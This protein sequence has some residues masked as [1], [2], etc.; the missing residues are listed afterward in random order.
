MYNNNN[1]SK[2]EQILKHMKNNIIILLATIFIL[3]CQQE[4]ELDTNDISII[5]DYR[6]Y[7]T[8]ES[9]IELEKI[10]L[11]NTFDN[12]WAMEF[13][14][15]ELVVITEKEGSLSLVNLTTSKVSQ[16]RHTIPV[17][18]YGQGG[19][20]DITYYKDNLYTTFTIKNNQGEYTTAIGKGEFVAPYNEI[21]NFEI[22]LEALPYLNSSKHFGSRILIQEDSIYAT[23]G[24]RGNGELSQ[25]PANHIGSVVEI[26]LNDTKTTPRFS[27]YKDSLPEVFQIGLRNPQGLALS[28]N[29]SM[30]LSNHGAKGGD[31]IGLVLP[32][33]NYGWNNIGWG[34]TNYIGTK[35]GNGEAFRD[36]YLKPIISWVP[37]IAP[38][39]IIFYEGS[40]FSEWS[41]D[42]LV[43]SLKF[44]MLLKISINDGNVS[45]ETIILKDK[46]GRI[47][48]VDINSRGEIF[49]I[50]DETNSTIWKISNPKRK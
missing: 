48:D 20:L 46:I 31:F 6:E 18:S 40:E 4:T 7:L 44:K 10:Q 27:N 43:T 14:N 2:Y 33:T 13:I 26:N 30:Y 38:S 23:I 8:N 9:L 50:T 28:I 11:T 29:G 47:R 1:Y 24:E 12:P 19:L 17:I 21:N 36:E 22:I 25:N 15:D 35:I 16:I 3:S 5:H 34:G 42:L 49:L 39:D 45:N 37:S 41:N 32:G